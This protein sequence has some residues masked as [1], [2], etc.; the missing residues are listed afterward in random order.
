MLCQFLNKKNI[1][2]YNTSTKNIKFDLALLLKT[3]YC[4]L[5]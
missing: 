4:Y 3:P 1:V 5:L 2:I